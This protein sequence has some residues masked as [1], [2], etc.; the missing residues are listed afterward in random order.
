M[1]S[2]FTT[3]TILVFLASQGFCQNQF[4]KK[5]KFKDGIYLNFEQLICNQPA[6]KLNPEI[7][8]YISGNII[9]TKILKELPLVY[10]N[11][12]EV[13]LTMKD[14]WVICIKGI[15]QKVTSLDRT[16]YVDY[17]LIPV[18]PTYSLS[19]FIFLGNITAYSSYKPE[20]RF[21]AMISK[22]SFWGYIIKYNNS[23]EASKLNIKSL[24]AF[25]QDDMDLYER[26]QKDKKKKRNLFAYISEYN[27]R[28][29]VDIKEQNSTAMSFNDR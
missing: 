5:F 9:H 17:D 22:K 15:P 29:P 26:F 19:R 8:A 6:F 13:K 27:Q 24:S 4:N 11:E 16:L 2:L 12:K 1:R 3:L 7:E 28:N 25:I 20:Y 10:K 23:S 14:L 21:S 18:E